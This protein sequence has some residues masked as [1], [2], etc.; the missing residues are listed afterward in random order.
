MLLTVEISLWRDMSLCFD[1]C[2]DYI[3]SSLSPDYH[4]FPR[5]SPARHHLFTNIP[6]SGK[7]GAKAGKDQQAAILP[8]NLYK[9]TI[10]LSQNKYVI[11]STLHKKN[12]NP[13]CLYHREGRKSACEDREVFAWRKVGPINPYILELCFRFGFGCGCSDFDTILVQMSSSRLLED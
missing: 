6:I 13:L 11:P 2:S 3:L 10:W 1:V 4:L 8:Q 7:A 9:R 5:L 12:C